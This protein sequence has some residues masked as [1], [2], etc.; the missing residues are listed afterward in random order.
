[1]SAKSML[2]AAPVA[3]LLCGAVTGAA[4]ASGG[5]GGGFSG[6]PS[7]S[8]PAYNA[9]EEYQK[10]VAALKGGDYREADRAFSHVLEVAPKDSNTLFAMGLNKVGEKDLKGAAKFYDLNRAGFAGGPNS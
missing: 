1:M 7:Y 3:V 5:G 10:G 4:L 2:I 6:A 9:V 8:A